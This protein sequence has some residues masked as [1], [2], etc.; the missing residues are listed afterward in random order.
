MKP[1]CWQMAM[2][3]AQ[4]QRMPYLHLLDIKKNHIKFLNSII[5]PKLCRIIL[6]MIAPSVKLKVDPALLSE[7][8]QRS[9]KAHPKLRKWKKNHIKFTNSTSPSNLCMIILDMTANIVNQNVDTA[10]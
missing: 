10:S 8:S 7:R 5:S 4:G 9:P 6:D 1:K 2:T 3:F